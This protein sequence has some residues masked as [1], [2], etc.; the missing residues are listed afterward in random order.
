M[1]LNPLLP[2]ARRPPFE[3]EIPLVRR[4]AVTLALQEHEHGCSDNGDEVEGEVHE[5]ANDGAGA[6]LFEGAFDY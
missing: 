5:V 3:L 4:W 2:L 1:V 6:V